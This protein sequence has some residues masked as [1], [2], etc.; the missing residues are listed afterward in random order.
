MKHLLSFAALLAA[1][2]VTSS[3]LALDPVQAKRIK[4]TISA[5]TLPEIPGL[6][7][8][9]V[10]QASKAE[11]SDVAITA[12]QAAIYKAPSSAPMVVAAVA[13]AAPDL[14]EVV[15]KKAIELEPTQFGAVATDRN[16]SGRHGITVSGTAGP[17]GNSGQGNRGGGGGNVTGFQGPG[18]HNPG[19]PLPN[20]PPHHN[21]P[22]HPLGGPPGLV[23]YS[24]PR[25]HH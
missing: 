12:V 15:L 11:Q 23:D 13:K 16:N 18:E 5:A 3:S 10:T 25:P 14:S 2:S 22:T 6:V 9:L 8:S 20:S 1:I 24:K 7:A 17:G 19:P 21:R 4:K